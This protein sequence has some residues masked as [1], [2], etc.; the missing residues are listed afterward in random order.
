MHRCFLKMLFIFFCVVHFAL[1]VNAFAEDEIHAQIS[2]LAENNQIYIKGTA[3]SGARFVT[4]RVEN[5]NNEIFYINQLNARSDG[6]FAAAVT[7]C[8]YLN[9]EYKIYISDDKTNSSVLYKQ[10]IELFKDIELSDVRVINENGEDVRE[11]KKGDRLYFNA[12]AANNSDEIYNIN[13]YNALYDING[14]IAD[15]CA[16]NFSVPPAKSK[17]LELSLITDNDKNLKAAKSFLWS[18]SLVPYSKSKINN[19]ID[20]DDVSRAEKLDS[21]SSESAEIFIFDFPAAFS[22]NKKLYIPVYIHNKDNSE[23]EAGVTAKLYDQNGATIFTNTEKISIKNGEYKIKNINSAFNVPNGVYNLNLKIEIGNELY[24]ADYRVRAV[25]PND[26]QVPDG[27]TAALFENSENINHGDFCDDVFDFCRGIKNNAADAVFY[28]PIL[29]PKAAVKDAD[30]ACKAEVLRGFLKKCDDL[31]TVYNNGRIFGYSFKRVGG[32]YLG[33]IDR[34]RFDG[35]IVSCF[36]G[37]EV[38]YDEYGNEILSEDVMFYELFYVFSD[39]IL[40]FNFDKQTAESYFSVNSASVKSVFA[41]SVVNPHEGTV[42]LTMNIDRPIEELA[43]V[44]WNFVFSAITA[45][46]PAANGSVN[47]FSLYVPPYPD[48]DLIFIT[49]EGTSAT[50]YA[51]CRNIQYESK[52]DINV[53]VTWKDGETTKMYI[54]GVLVAESQ[55][56]IAIDEEYIPYEMTVTTGKPFNVSRMQIYSK[57]MLPGQ[58]YKNPSDKFKADLNTTM[59]AD[60]GFEKIEYFTSIWQKET[61]YSCLIPAYRAEKQIFSENDK[62]VYPVMA[63]NCGN[64]SV[65]YSVEFLITDADGNVCAVTEKSVLIKNDGERYI[66]EI[67][68]PE[69]YECGIYSITASIKCNGKLTGTFE[70]AISVLPTIDSNTED[71]KYADYYGME[72]DEKTDDEV[73]KKL[74]ASITRTQRVFSWTSVEPIKSSF[75]WQGADEYVDRCIKNNIEIVAVLGKFPAWAAK[76]PTEEEKELYYSD[77]NGNITLMSPE[78]WKPKN[79]EEWANYVYSVVSRYKGR[80]KYWEVVNEANFHPPYKPASYSGT[81]EEYYELLKAAYSAAKRADPDCVVLTSGFAVPINGMTDSEMPY[82]LTKKKYAKGY[83]DIFN[84]HGYSG[85]AAFESCID[86]LKSENPN[87]KYIMSEYMPYR[88]SGEGNK[89]YAEITNVLDFAYEGY[90][91]YIDMGLR[92][93]ANVYLTYANKS[94]QKCFHATAVLNRFLSKCNEFVSKE[95]HEDTV[96]YTLKRTDGKYLTVI[97]TG[98]SDLKNINIKGNISSVYDVYGRK[99]ADAETDMQ[100]GL[101]DNNKFSYVISESTLVCE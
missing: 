65:M 67:Q 34:T 84:V 23:K 55:N 32:G 45:K 35:D 42:Q 59:L 89:I 41:H 30:Y 78:R 68:L 13:F 76:E 25:P 74:N 72:L 92:S 19:Y 63:V 17:R 20:F 28:V 100:I 86:N 61:E 1:V 81:S 87:A 46:K 82:E 18:N 101:S 21:F 96:I 57:R 97:G 33:I 22:N 2:V 51:I 53:A 98:G 38:F 95:M 36:S 73:L 80:V 69:I 8:E 49:R 10:N 15:V 14:G 50:S 93:N 88:E 62:I 77:G 43:N 56:A 12:L 3:S 52:R 26:R 79:I 60:D 91:K 24:R 31:D 9:G 94:P 90:D 47:V 48:K 70:S 37:N 58:L 66:Y 16:K 27:D 7:L 85:I 64:S 6:S 5:P 83:Y 54:G 11:L 99:I 44:S 75:V 40:N 29:T 71:G 39:G 4:V